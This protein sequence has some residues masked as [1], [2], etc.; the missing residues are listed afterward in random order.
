MHQPALSRRTVRSAGAPG[1]AGALGSTTQNR[2]GRSPYAGDPA[3]AAA[4]RS[5]YSTGVLEW[6]AFQA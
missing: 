5:G 1:A 3:L 6:K 2:I 4:S